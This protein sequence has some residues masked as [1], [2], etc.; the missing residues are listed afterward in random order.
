MEKL[1]RHWPPLAATLVLLLLYWRGFDCWFYQDDFGW[2][3]LGPARSFAEFLDILFVPKAHGNIRPWSENLFFYGL[4]ALFGMN[5]L[6]FRIVVFATFA[7]SLYLLD[8]LMRRLAGTALASFAAQV[9]W[10]ANSCVAPAFCWTSIHNQPQYVFFL[11]LALWL[12]VRG[13]LRAHVAVFCLSLGALE[14]A[15][16]YPAIASLYALLFDRGKLRW[17]APL[18]LVSA[19]YTAL[20]FYAAPAPP[21]GPYAIRVDARIFSTFAAYARLALGPDRLLHFYWEWPRWLG[22]AASALMAAGVLAAAAAARRPG[23]FGLGW[24]ALLL[25]PMLPLPDHVMDYALTGPALGLAVVLGSALASRYRAPA[26]L[27]VAFYLAAS[28]PA[29]SRTLRW[30]WERS[31]TARDLV[32]GVVAYHRAHPYMTLLLTGMDTNQF[33]AGFADLP[34]EL[35][36]MYR[37]YL[38]PGAE[39][40]VHDEARIA[41]LYVLPPEQAWPLIESGEAAVLDVSAQPVR[42]VTAEFARAHRGQADRP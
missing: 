39:K 9:C 31:H 24:F 13:N 18:F 37:V 19:A 3:H 4:H 5:P 27:L 8:A 15:V 14:T 22:H 30:N 7:A 21:D 10:I 16:M 6:P 34:F 42:D 1:K 11:L 33:L 36:G 41:P 25:T 35:Y 40:N 26:A 29:A 2:L 12:F 28:L 38:A 17:A 23:W 20:H 32:T